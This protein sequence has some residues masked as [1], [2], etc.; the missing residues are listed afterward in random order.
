[1]EALSRSCS[2][3]DAWST[4]KNGTICL[5]AN[6]KDKVVGSVADRQRESPFGD[7]G[8]PNPGTRCI[9]ITPYGD[10]RSNS[11]YDH[12]T[13]LE[14]VDGMARDCLHILGHSVYWQT[15]DTPKPKEPLKKLLTLE[16]LLWGKY[17]CSNKKV[18]YRGLGM[19]LFPAGVGN[20]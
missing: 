9:L 10:L 20:P 18:A 8:C 17:R 15:N 7:E 5:R 16:P 14:L 11:T 13:K 6:R 19:D 1:M 12:D 3:K 2:E 4:E